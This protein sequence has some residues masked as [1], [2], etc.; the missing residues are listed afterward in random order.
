MARTLTFAAERGARR[1]PVMRSGPV[2]PR[3]TAL[4]VASALFMENMDSSVIATSLPAIARDIGADPIALKLAFT[5]YLLSL[6]VFIPVSGWAADRFGARTVFASAIAVFTAGSIACGLSSSLE[7]FVLA[8]VLQGLG[9]AMMTPVGRLVV[10]RS[11]PKHE[12][13][14]LIA[15]LT[16][17]ALIGPLIG[18]PLGGFISTYFHWRWIFW[19]NVPVGILGIALALL[20]V[21]N[22]VAPDRPRF[23]RVGFVLS[24]LGLSGLVFGLSVLGQELI[25]LKVAV[26][27]VAVG[28]VSTL[29][30]VRH[31]RRTPHAILDLKLF[32]LPTFRASVTGGS[33]FRVGIGAIPFLL[34]LMLQLGLGMTAFESGSLTFVAAIGAL[35]MKLTAAPLVRRFGFKRL[36][37]VNGFV[38]AGFVFLTGL[39]ALGVPSAVILTVLLVGGFLRSL[40]FTCLNTVAYAEVSHAAMSRAT[41][42]SSVVQQV[43]LSTGV[44]VGALVLETL[45]AARPGETILASDFLVGFC[46]VGAITLLAPFIFAR[47]PR[48]AGAEM[49]RR[50]DPDEEDAAADAVPAK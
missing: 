4:I 37:V 29:L 9:G 33:L 34:P 11:A 22:I 6:A 15:W 45:R 36:L 39:F 17:P 20:Y 46:V 18:P 2:S 44:A 1:G 16:T 50:R 14:D 48:D 25:P 21:P 7:G 12:I 38:S 41:S 8:R 26:V 19:V 5:S 43:S 10:L 23:D 40:Q 13:V 3:F 42:L 30:Y 24:G 27:L 31:A 35:T 47:L 32:R 28:S 49:A